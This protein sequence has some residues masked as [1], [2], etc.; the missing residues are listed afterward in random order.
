M[1]C[2]SNVPTCLALAVGLLGALP[3]SGRAADAASAPPAPP[4]P[5]LELEFPAGVPFAVIPE[6]VR[7]E[8]EDMGEGFALEQR[9]QGKVTLRW[10]TQPDKA[11]G[12]NELQIRQAD[13]RI[14]IFLTSPTRVLIEPKAEPW[15]EIKVPEKAT[16]MLIGDEVTSDEKALTMRTADRAEI[17]LPDGVRLVVRRSLV[18]LPRDRQRGEQRIR[19]GPLAARK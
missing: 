10:P 6:G 4:G 3:G 13:I 12:P 18:A 2:R 15:V 8:R 9:I 16:V 1:I 19:I 7:T 14:R 11:T 17:R 5:T